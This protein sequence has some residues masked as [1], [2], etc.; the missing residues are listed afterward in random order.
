MNKKRP[1]AKSIFNQATGFTLIE[2]MIVV[3]IIGILATIAY[4]SYQNSVK[5]S[6]RADAKSALMGFVNAMERH[7]TETNSY[8]DAAAAGE[9]AV[10]NCGDGTPDKGKPAVFAT[11]SPIDG[12]DKYYDLTIHAVG[13]TTYTLRATPKGAQAGDGILEI[14]NTESRGRWDRNNDGDF[15]DANE[16]TWD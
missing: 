15:A 1:H 12:T 7:Y 5:K 6:R 9:T 14:K 11:E 4:P 8:C 10:T 3:A 2:L 16:G 13:P